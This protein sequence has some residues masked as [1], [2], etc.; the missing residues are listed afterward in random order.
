MSDNILFWIDS[1]LIQFG[2]AKSIQDKNNANLYAIFDI[3]QSMKN[4][5]ENQ[6]IVN[7]Q[8]EWY[9]WDNVK[10]E[11]RQPDIK[12]LESFEKKYKI[13]I[14]MIS[15]IEATFSSRNQYHKFGHDEILLILEKECRFFE[16]ILEEIKPKYLVI[17][18]TDYHRNHLLMKMCNSLGIKILMLTPTII[19][20]RSRI[21]EEYNIQYD[22]D[23]TSTDTKDIKNFTELKKYLKQFN[24][25]KQFQKITAGGGKESLSNRIR[26]TSKWMKTN[27]K[28]DNTRYDHY[29]TTK[30]KILITRTVNGLKKKNREFFINKKSTYNIEKDENIIYFPLQV[31]P[32]RSLSIDSPFHIN[33]L[34]V[35][36]NI[37]K[38]IPIGYKLYVKENFGQIFRGWREQ[39]FYQD[40]L[41]LPNVV[42]VHH[43][44]NPEIL[45]E[46]CKLVITISG[47]S[48]FESLLYEKPSIVFTDVNYGNIGAV[49]K[50][51]KIEE[52][53]NI[54]RQS[55]EQKVD[56]IELNKFI[57]S[58]I[59][60]SFEFN[61]VKLQNIIYE[62]F[63]HG[64]L[65]IRRNITKKELQ[66]FLEEQKVI[67]DNL[68]LEFIKKMQR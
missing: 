25:Y 17:K 68:G 42:L 9:F 13:N 24:K 41:D 56:L 38:S 40:I 30:S 52:L 64:G 54:I 18:F 44:I 33:Q 37:A 22:L 31:E 39:K 45:F 65:S 11:K 48:G 60:N 55:L 35:I 62:K 49:N 46:K 29:G 26:I 57:E 20:Y 61:E 4:L 34:E 59:K 27:E 51:E 32:E 16:K 3:S 15:N 67:F 28:E 6:K 66:S 1:V 43:S 47:T 53:P 21:S 58:V 36:K 10:I 14:W 23:K 5:F 50:V 19:G 63:H 7:F 12:Y 8:K 2:I